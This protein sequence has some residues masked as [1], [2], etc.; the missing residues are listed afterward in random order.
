MDSTG[1]QRHR[2]AFAVS[3]LQ[4]SHFHISTLMVNN[5]KG[6]ERLVR[7]IKKEMTVNPGSE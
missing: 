2:L 6:V 5:T 7:E 1:F 4:M 3:F